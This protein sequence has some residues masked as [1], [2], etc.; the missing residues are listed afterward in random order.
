M[1][2]LFEDI[3]Q[4]EYG[5]IDHMAWKTELNI[6]IHHTSYTVIEHCVNIPCSSVNKYPLLRHL[7]CPPPLKN[8]WTPLAAAHFI[9]N[10]KSNNIKPQTYFLHLCLAAI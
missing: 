1:L 9:L 10:F 2:I 8:Q 4:Q 7:A 6:L 5:S 3:W